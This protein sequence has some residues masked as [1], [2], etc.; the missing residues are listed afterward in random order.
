M[1]NMVVCSSLAMGAA[2]GGRRALNWIHPTWSAC[3]ELHNV[4]ERDLTMCG[5][6]SN[7]QTLLSPSEP[8]KEER[9]EKRKQG[10]APALGHIASAWTDAMAAEKQVG[11]HR[12][13]GRWSLVGCLHAAV[14]QAV[15]WAM[16]VAAMA[17]CRLMGSFSQPLLEIISDGA[18]LGEPI[19]QIPL[20]LGDH[21]ISFHCLQDIEASRNVSPK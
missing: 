19:P 12:Q 8:R 5:N 17:H 14:P 15:C 18:N 10:K 7:K 1:R 20:M 2:Q 11:R 9:K 21:E 4:R 16:Q 3:A 13:K 6:K